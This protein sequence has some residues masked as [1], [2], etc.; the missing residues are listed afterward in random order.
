MVNKLE[1][2]KA[3]VKETREMIS[4]WMDAKKT[5]AVETHGCQQLKERLQRV[6]EKVE[7][8]IEMRRKTHAQQWIS[9]EEESSVAK[10]L[11]EFRRKQLNATARTTQAT[12]A[13]IEINEDPS[14]SNYNTINASPNPIT[15]PLSAWLLSSTLPVLS[16]FSLY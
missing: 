7:E 6:E 1:S 9:E 10:L 8:E 13:D 3:H 11:A 12:T 15:T 16:L 14:H 2:K 4:V 5:V